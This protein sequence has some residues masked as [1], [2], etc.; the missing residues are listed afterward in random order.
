VLS[1]RSELTKSVDFAVVSPRTW[2]LSDLGA[3]LLL[4]RAGIGWGNMP[5]PMV[6]ED[7]DSG[8]LVR[9]DPPGALAFTYRLEAIYRSDSP[10]GPAG[11]WLIERFRNQA[12]PEQKKLK[13]RKPAKPATLRRE[14]PQGRRKSRK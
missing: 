13:P 2:R 10:P 9:L 3:K 8:S 7:L 14:Q 5:L 11:S 6:Q 1:D 12:T 4:L